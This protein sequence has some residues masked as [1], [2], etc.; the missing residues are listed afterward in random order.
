[1]RI[2]PAILLEWGVERGALSLDDRDGHFIGGKNFYKSEIH[3][4]DQSMRHHFYVAGFDVTMDNGRFLA[5]QEGQSIGNLF[6]PS[7]NFFF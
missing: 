4:F 2:V 7:K 5:V 1:V 6:R 3:K